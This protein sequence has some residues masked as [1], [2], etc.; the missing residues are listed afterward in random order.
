MT[1]LANPLPLFLDT[2]GALMDGGH[3]YVGTANGNP[4]FTPIN[5]FW[6]F[7]Q[8]QP[9]TQP[10]RTIG[11]Q[12]VNGVTPAAVFFTESDYAIRVTDQ[13]DVLAFYSPSIYSTL[14]FQPLDSDLTA[15]AALATTSYGRSLLTL[16][17]Q[18]ALVAATGIAPALP[19]AG[20]TVTGDILRQDSGSYVY[21]TTGTGAKIYPPLPV[22]TANP[23][24]GAL[25][26]QGFY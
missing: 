21:A 1:K 22:G 17:N 26:L 20:G 9:A 16:A 13:N 10:L 5:V 4:L 12:V 18:A 11:G 24:T 23:A 6:D 8:T 25:S 3:I 19:L 7:A 2:R 15:I 14:S